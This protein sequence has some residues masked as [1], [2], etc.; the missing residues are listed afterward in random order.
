V[1]QALLGSSVGR[2]YAAAVLAIAV[3][4]VV[5]LVV[6]WP[7]QGPTAKLAGFAA[8]EPGTVTR[9]AEFPCSGFQTDRCRRVAVRLDAGSE[10]GRTVGIELGTGGLDPELE[11]GDQ[12]RVAKDVAPPGAP[13]GTL[14]SL[15]DF[16]R[17]P[18]MLWLAIAFGVLVVLLGRLRG[19]LSVLGLGVS[20]AVVLA[21][22][23]PAILGGRP[24]LAVAIVG[25]SAIMLATILLAHGLNAKSLA[26]LLGTTASLLLTAALAV[27]FTGL[28]HLTGFATEEAVLLQT[29]EAGVSLTGL[30]IAGMVIAALGVLDDLTISQASTVMALHAARPEQ[31][32]SELYRRGLAVGRDHVT[33]TVNTLVLAYVGA[34]LPVLLVLTLGEVGTLEA[35]NFEIVA[36]EIVATLVGSIGLIAAVPVTTALAAL[37]P[38]STGSASD[39]Q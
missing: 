37:V 10:A 32:F 20:I 14:Y 6:L 7:T 23:L 29:S 4:T 5:A 8:T 30:L 1:T 33:A 2:V 13:G 25:A 22:I 26:A 9:I 19:A 21:F 12:I 24:P 35:V 11:L 17:R 34:S 38:A 28:T 27:A 31:R 3:S 16:E 15:A 36:K 18:P 39:T